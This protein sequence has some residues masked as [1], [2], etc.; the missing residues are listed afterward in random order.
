M[1][2]FHRLVDRAVAALSVAKREVIRCLT[3]V[4]S[5]TSLGADAAA[6]NLH[7]ALEQLF[8]G[9]DA[10]PAGYDVRPW[11]QVKH[12]CGIVCTCVCDV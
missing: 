11:I 1:L 3:R 5:N 7:L 10:E 8:N 9:R 2:W 12:Y 6:A 4:A